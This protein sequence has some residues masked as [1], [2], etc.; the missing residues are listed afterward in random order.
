MESEPQIEI[1]NSEKRG[2][3][4]PKGSSN[5]PQIWNYVTPDEVA[6][7]MTL[8]K[9][10]AREKPE[11]LKFLLEQIFGKAKQNLGLEGGDSGLPIYVI[12]YG[13]DINSTSVST[14]GFSTRPPESTPEV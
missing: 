11:L 4:R 7:L 1:N 12:K 9:E 5:K 3:G 2:P 14:E 8:A 10:Q 13:E 6:E